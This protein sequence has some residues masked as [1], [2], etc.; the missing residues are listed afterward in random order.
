MLCKN[1]GTE[2]SEGVFCPECGTKNE[3]SFV[4]EKTVAEMVE[5]EK[6][7]IEE[8]TK[9][10]ARKRVESERASIREKAEKEIR[11]KAIREAQKEAEKNISFKD[12]DIKKEASRRMREEAIQ[13]AKSE[14]EHRQKEEAER[15]VKEKKKID[16]KA[17]FS[18]ILGIVSWIGIVTVIVPIVG[19]IWSIIDGV[20]A[21]KGKTKYRKCAIAGIVISVFLFLFIVLCCVFF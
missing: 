12:E 13:K 9:E 19:G 6:K 16:R 14:E 17:V 18:L 3:E 4:D 8:A 2:F 21:L 7:L 11:E 1:C 10:E 20:K 5:K 15:K